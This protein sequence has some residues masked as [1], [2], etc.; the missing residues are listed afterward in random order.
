MNK[1]QLVNEV[2]QKTGMTKKDSEKAVTATFE[3]IEETLA[4]LEKVQLVGFGTF[5]VKNRAERT[6]RNPQTQE[7]MIIPA[8]N[9]PHFKA[10]KLL[11]DAVRG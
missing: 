4:K 8:H 9:T 3:V 11:K 10:G 1:Q 2:A 5:E 7:T 6:G